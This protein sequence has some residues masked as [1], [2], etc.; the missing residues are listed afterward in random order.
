[1]IQMRNELERDLQQQYAEKESGLQNDI[2]L[3]TTERDQKDAIIRKHDKKMA[4]AKTRYDQAE[5]ATQEARSD[6]EAVRNEKVEIEAKLHNMQRTTHTT[7]SCNSAIT[8]L[9]DRLRQKT[10]DLERKKEEVTKL[11]RECAELK[12]ANADL[13]LNYEQQVSD[14]SQHSHIVESLR[15]ENEAERQQ[16][17][18]QSRAAIEL[19]ENETRAALK[20]K[21]NMQAQLQQ[22]QIHESSLSSTRAALVIERDNLRNK[23]AELEAVQEAS[24]RHV[25][26]LQEQ[27][28]EEVQKCERDIVDWRRRHE[29]SDAALKE[30]EAKIQLQKT[31]H[32]RKLEYDEEKYKGIVQALAD[33]LDKVKAQVVNGHNI[34]Q[35]VCQSTSPQTGVL[36][37]LENPQPGKTRKKVHRENNSVLGV[38]K[39]SG[40]HKPLATSHQDPPAGSA[41]VDPGDNLFDEE[42]QDD[43]LSLVDPALESVEDT[44]EMA[45]PMMMLFSDFASQA[46][47]EARGR[48]ERRQST[49]DEP[50]SSSADSDEL[51]RMCADSQRSM[52]S[53]TRNPSDHSDR[54]LLTQQRVAETPPRAV[55]APTS[56]LRSPHS[57]DRPRSQANTASRMMPPP[58]TNPSVEKRKPNSVA[59]TFRTSR[60]AIHEKRGDTTRSEDEEF[61]GSPD[62]SS[63]HQSRLF[64]DSAALT[65]LE[66]RPTKSLQSTDYTQCDK[67]KSIEDLDVPSKRQR[68]AAGSR[69]AGSSSDARAQSPYSSQQTTSGT[70]SRQHVSLLQHSASSTT[71]A[72]SRSRLGSAI[73]RTTG[74]GSSSDQASRSRNQQSST[75]RS[76]AAA[77]TSRVTNGRQL[78]QQS[79]SSHRTRSKGKWPFLQRSTCALLIM[80]L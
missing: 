40:V 25:L 18:T 16:E 17:R 51:D 32:Q 19:A 61:W 77:R 53:K 36:Q 8:D 54:E 57:T 72:Y 55:H 27:K 35:K 70:R 78:T 59:N 49:S 22:A 24:E 3:L 37:S 74:R 44:Q 64:E 42:P 50:L 13:K 66:G 45:G 43:A 69:D 2:H 30:A 9:Q 10:D 31:E 71:N 62:Q 65:A 41:D 12:S 1:M 75:P 73:S 76:S 52:I 38:T 15:Q 79:S 11:E 56:N 46:D 29:S 67:R 14:I 5:T 48:M 4:S 80:L 7:S 47:P 33:E 58:G 26:R 21:D 6:L 34:Q 63:P 39:L 28:D 20:Q 68:N 60:K 23:N